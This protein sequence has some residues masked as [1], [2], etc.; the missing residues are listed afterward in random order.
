MEMIKFGKNGSDANTAAVRLARAIS[1]RQLIAYDTSAPFIS[2]HDWFIG[3]TVTNAG[4][5]DATSRLSVPFTYNDTA[6]VEA[7]FDRFP[8]EIALLVMEVCRETKPAPGFLETVRRL[9]TKHGTLLHFD[10]I[11][12]GFRYNLNGAHSMFAV[13]PDL[14]AIGKG[15]ANGYALSALLGKRV[16]MERGG[17]RHDKERV[18][19]MSTTNGPEQ[20]ALA[21][22][23]ATVAF[24]REHDVIGRLAQTGQQ[25]SGHEPRYR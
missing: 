24:Y 1:G 13:T 23:I 3:T 15:M 19:F 10:E 5:P 7:L 11:I 2:I 21:A 6:S 25:L 4:V 17:L 22:S 12:T 8:N 14:L 16:H 20:S 18:F 9:C